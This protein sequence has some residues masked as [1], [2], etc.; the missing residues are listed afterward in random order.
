MWVQE[1]VLCCTVHCT[2]QNVLKGCCAIQLWMAGYST[3]EGSKHKNSRKLKSSDKGP[4]NGL[5]EPSSQVHSLDRL[6]GLKPAVVNIYCPS[7]LEH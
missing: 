3:L 1:Q 6:E 4:S 7:S 5:R 2:T